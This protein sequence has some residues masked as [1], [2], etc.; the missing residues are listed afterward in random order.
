MKFSFDPDRLTTRLFLE[1]DTGANGAGDTAATTAGDG[2]E[3][4][5][6]LEEA[7]AELLSSQQPETPTASEPAASTPP[8][9]TAAASAE[10]QQQAF[11]VMN[12]LRDRGIDYGFQN[13][14]DAAQFT[15]QTFRLLQQNYDD[16]QTLKQLKPYLPQFQ[17]FVASQWQQQQ[18]PQ[19][20]QPTAAEKKRWAE[21][22]E[23]DPM[24]RQMVE[25]DPETGKLRVA[26]GYDPSVLTK[27]QQFELRRQ[28]IAEQML[29]D[30]PGFFEPM[31]N[32][33]VEMAVEKALSAVQEKFFSPVREHLVANEIYQRDQG[34]MYAT[35]EQ[36]QRT[37]T[38][39]GQRYF[40]I[41]Q[42]LDQ[43]GIK[44]AEQ[45]SAMA[46]HQLQQEM[47]YWG[48]YQQPQQAVP[49]AAPI[50]AAVANPTAQNNA[51]K[52]RLLQQ[53][54]TRSPNVSAR[55]QASLHEDPATSLTDMALA[56][57]NG[58]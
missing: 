32:E 26:E 47:A 39:E 44:N 16:L 1:A 36:G 2:E 41:L 45:A 31:Q 40:Q 42:N 11:S 19:Q 33:T 46:K 6:G 15:E 4:G 22:L 14:Q 48:A 9:E 37:F 38:R 18:Q 21:K 24:W 8:A 10:Q 5:A 55:A 17:Q 53:G 25:R 27:L 57:L 52:Q 58:N 20:Q 30:L 13:E 7:S 28:Q 56:R 3:F 43:M 23:F 49:G 35:N 34:W 29:T 50:P 12:Y 51:A 54:R